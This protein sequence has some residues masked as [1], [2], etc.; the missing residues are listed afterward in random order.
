MSLCLPPPKQTPETSTAATTGPARPSPQRHFWTEVGQPEEGRVDPAQD[1]GCMERGEG[2]GNTQVC[3]RGIL[4]DTASCS[5]CIIFSDL[6][7]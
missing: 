1:L 7:R 5:P 3:T 6:L 2:L 4:H